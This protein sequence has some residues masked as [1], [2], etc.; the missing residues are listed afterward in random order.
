MTETRLYL[1]ERRFESRSSG[2]VRQVGPPWP[3]DEISS[4]SISMTSAPAASSAA[5]VSGLPFEHDAAPGRDE[6]A[7]CSPCCRTPPRAARPGRKMS[8]RISQSRKRSRHQRRIDQ[9][10][11]A[12]DGRKNRHQMEDVGPTRG[13]GACRPP[14]PR[15][16]ARRGGQAGGCPRRCC[17]R[18]GRPRASG[19]QA[20]PCRR[21]PAAPPLRWRRRQECPAGDRPL[22]AMPGSPRR[23]GLPMLQR[24]T[25]AGPTMAASRT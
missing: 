7:R 4:P 15:P 6:P 8:R 1:I 19:R 10:Q 2:R 25:P 23:S 5:R 9:R 24:I 20:T 14:P 17:D 21:P 16:P 3:L 12:V 22:P 13:N 11:I 18:Y